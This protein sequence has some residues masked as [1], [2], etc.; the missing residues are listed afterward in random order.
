MKMRYLLA[1]L[2]VA[3]AS[4][5]TAPA[6]LASEDVTPFIVGGRPVTENYTFMVYVGGCTG[7]LIKADWAVTA[8]HC[9]TPSS[10][11]VGSNDR[12]KGGTVVRVT[13]GVNHPSQD[14]KL[15]QLANPV[16]HTP[17]PI[18]QQASPDGTATRL[19]GWGQ[20]CPTRGCGR[21]PAVAHEFD[22][23]ILPDSRCRGIKGPNEICTNNPN[24]G[25]DCFGDS[26]GPQITKV[27]GAWRLI[28]SDSRG[29]S[30]V[31]GA[32]PSIYVDLTSV[33][34]WIVQ[35]AGALP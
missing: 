10:V 2:A 27:N 34:P 13:R 23:S 14:V 3:A 29:T 8:K 7:S 22:T 31:C 9:G 1:S 15:L 33:R 19:L 5:L 20:T 18:P 35:Q 11:R 16:T 4:V 28:G 32:A 21:G 25:G 30:A 12:T 17:I 6:S 26:G 24:K